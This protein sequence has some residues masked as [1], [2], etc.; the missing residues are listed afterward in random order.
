[1][2]PIAK[3]EENF[4]KT[5]E[6][7]QKKNEKTAPQLF[8][9]NETV[10]PN[11]AALEIKVTFKNNPVYAIL[12]TGSN[13]SCINSS[14][15]SETDIQPGSYHLMAANNS[16]LQVLGKVTIDF[17]V[18]NSNCTQTVYVVKKLGCP[19]ILGNNFMAQNKVK[20]DFGTHTLHIP[21]VKNPVSICMN[22]D[23]LE[24]K[25]FNQIN[26]LADGEGEEPKGPP[27][28]P[29]KT[30]EDVLLAPGQTVNV[31]LRTPE[32]P[33]VYAATTTFE[34]ASLLMK[35][36]NLFAP[37]LL[38]CQKNSPATL[39]VTNMGKT[40][41]WLPKD[42]TV[43]H[44]YTPDTPV[45]VIF[46]H[47]SS[48]DTNSYP[49]Q[50]ERINFV[51]NLTGPV[52]GRPPE[53]P[54]RDA[55][56]QEI[57]INPDLDST[58]AK[59]ARK[60]ISENIELF[61]ENILDLGES[62]LPDREILVDPAYKPTID[63]PFRHSLEQRNE[64]DRTVDK[65][66][67]A[68]IVEPSH[69]AQ[70]SPAFMVPKKAEPGQKPEWRMVISYKKINKYILNDAFPLPRADCIFDTLE[71]QS[72]FCQMDIFS[73]YYQ[74]RIRPE[75]RHWTAFVTHKGLYQFT[76]L[77]M[78]MK[79]SP[80]GFQRS[81]NV[82]FND[83]LYHGL[84]L[85]LDDLLGYARNFD[86]MVQILTKIFAILRK[87][88]LKLKTTKCHFFYQKVEVLGHV[89]SDKGIAASPSKVEAILALKPAS[90]VSETRSLI[91]SFG[92]YRRYIYR[93][94]DIINSLI[95]L[96]KKEN[97]HKK[98]TWSQ[99]N[100]ESLNN[101]K[102]ALMSAPTL[103]HFNDQKPCTVHCD[104][105][106]VGVSGILS[107]PDEE[108]NL[109]PV[110]YVS[111]KLTQNERH[112]SATEIEM[113]A[114][115]YTL[116]YWRHY[117]IGKEITVVTDHHSLLSL[118]S[119]KEQNFRLS[120]MATKLIDFTIV[121]IRH[122]KG[123][124][125][126]MRPVDF[127]SRHPCEKPVDLVDE[128]DKLFT[129][130]INSVHI[131]DFLTHAQ[132]QDSLELENEENPVATFNVN[133]VNIPLLQKQDPYLHSIYKAIFDVKSATKV[134]ARQSRHFEVNED[135]V[136]FYKKFTYPRK[137][138]LLA[139]PESLKNQILT[140]YHES[141]F[142]GGHA[143]ASRMHKK[144][145]Q[146]YWWK[147]CLKDVI[148]F[149]QTCQLCQ[150][151]KT[152]RTKKAGKLHPIPVLIG[153]PFFHLIIDT[154]GPILV[155][156]YSNKFIF[157]AKCTLTKFVIT[158]AAAKND[159]PTLA[160]FIL[161]D[162]VLR[163]GCP[164]RITSDRGSNYT[165]TVVKHLLSGLGVPQNWSTAYH[166]AS[167]GLV[168]RQNASI[169]EVL[170]HYVTENQ[171]NWSQ[172]LPFV[173]FAYNIAPTTSGYSPFFLVHGFEPRTPID[174][175]FLPK[176]TDSDILKQLKMLTKIREEVP[177]IIAKNQAKQKER[178]DQHRKTI[179]FEPGEKC[180]L[181]S[182]FN[183]VGLSRKLAA[184]RSG[185]FKVLRK[186]S[187]VNYEIQLVKNGQL[188]KDTVHVE[189]MHK[190]YERESKEEK[191]EKS[192]AVEKLTAREGQGKPEVASG[193]RECV[194]IITLMENNADLFD[195]RL[196]ELML[197]EQER[198][199]MQPFITIS[200][201]PHADLVCTDDVIQGNNGLGI[202][203][204]PGVRRV[205]K[206][207]MVKY[208]RNSEKMTRSSNVK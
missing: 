94:T 87:Y 163:F 52:H 82:I 120:K 121:K 44:F 151:C 85:Y 207:K 20:I 73:A 23:W 115:T 206:T 181:T 191:E 208:D 96:T 37:D 161:N 201:L 67:E 185:P 86:E 119:F 57:D 68:G 172:M 132:Q 186:I 170:R 13:V 102:K 35:K 6:N 59:I 100:E 50:S 192:G 164:G 11:H 41:H 179:N 133:L 92:Y 51:S 190:F 55:A 184:Q 144:I 89:V 81:M 200:R 28:I 187:D 139:V 48:L 111:R 93:Y 108:N 56:G 53:I 5:A 199:T 21:H 43:G 105:S 99:E 168:E 114:L 90:S 16:Q 189:R 45:E 25:V 176:E 95:E 180:L 88:K 2:R 126:E 63:P 205:N 62:E 8:T 147:S 138:K 80:N 178:F 78:G 10:L 169:L 38:K 196:N 19:L 107:Q 118:D 7:T 9:V 29:A 74:Q 142:S 14:L 91:G 143:G 30:M 33:P 116:N 194:A 84:I 65:L 145:V 36:R 27:P 24:T 166:P 128:E 137:L 12:D 195:K 183:T 150:K 113:L 69:A 154:I 175:V 197:R 77:P 173:T 71:G 26:L 49:S 39:R 188:T 4:A 131:Y 1:M 160:K 162:V 134:I 140:T 15:I 156:S 193:D 149:C 46:K 64:L 157:V 167:Q 136:L 129:F 152:D 104:A 130:N 202:L 158:K 83:L 76:R 177:A 204:F 60:L 155:K 66:S 61:A 47:N 40:K 17:N 3:K 182:P 124:A 135:D 101:L 75:D 122:A 153:Q 148:K 18:E 97:E 72:Y 22:T 54:L 125:P 146:K 171:K 203:T 103:I 70:A 159:A 165:A 112:W 117:L 123:T 34:A 106:K 98:F 127:L 31:P 198:R 42:S 79:T 32:I 141:P 174:V 109:H 58:K 110:S